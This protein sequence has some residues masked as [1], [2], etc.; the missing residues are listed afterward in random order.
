MLDA[1]QPDWTIFWRELAR[2]LPADE[3]G[4]GGAAAACGADEVD[5]LAASFYAAPPAA[6]RADL[7]AWVGAWHAALREARVAPAD[8]AATMRAANPKY[9][10]REWMLVAAYTAAE[11]GDNAPVRELHELFRRPYDEQPEFE[12][13]FHRRADARAAATG[14]VGFMT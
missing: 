14:G 9:V 12:A 1:L 3:G 7:L 13:R 8:A 11:A 10:P 5:K 2:L 6:V 4:A